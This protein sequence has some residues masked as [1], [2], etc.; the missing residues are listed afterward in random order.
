MNRITGQVKFFSKNRGYGFITSLEDDKDYFAFHTEISTSS[1]CFHVLYKNEFVEFSIGE[2]PKGEQ[3]IRITGIKG[4]PMLCEAGIEYNTKRGGKR[5]NNKIN[6]K[7]IGDSNESV[8]NNTEDDN[9]KEVSKNEEGK[10][11]GVKE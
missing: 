3:A 9:G 5:Q 8:E 2:G 10:Q 1:N 6:E 4:R 7:I 11:D